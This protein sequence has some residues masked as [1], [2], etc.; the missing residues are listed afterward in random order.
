ME[1]LQ[2]YTLF[3][4]FIK[5]DFRPKYGRGR[6]TTLILQVLLARLH[7]AIFPGAVRM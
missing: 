5:D 3:I 7:F 2:R 4:L 1:T 6:G